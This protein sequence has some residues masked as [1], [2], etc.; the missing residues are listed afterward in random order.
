MH[1]K[2]FHSLLSVLLCTALVL[3]C[4][5]GCGLQKEASE[6]TET[7]TQAFSWQDQFDL[8][9]RYLSEDNY[10]AAI[11]A[12]T[13]A[14]EID[15]KNVDAYI[16][17]APA[18]VKAAEAIAKKG[19]ERKGE[20][21]EYLDNATKDYH[22][23]IELDPRWE[24]TYLPEIKHVLTIVDYINNT[25]DI[26]IVDFDHL[27]EIN[28]GNLTYDELLDMIYS[29]VLANWENLDDEGWDNPNDPDSVSYLL[30]RISPD[31]GLDEVGYMLLDLD[32][33]GQD[34]LLI[35]DV[36]LAWE[37]MFHDLY[38]IHDG[39]LVHL[40]SSGERDRHYLA[41]DKSINNIGSSGAASS[42]NANY[43][44]NGTTGSLQVTNA[45]I[46]EGYEN[47]SNP[48]FLAQEDS[49]DHSTYEYRYDIMEN[50]SQETAHE[51]IAG[52]PENMPITLTLFSTYHPASETL[53]PPQSTELL[54]EDQAYA[55]ACDFLGYTEGDVDNQ[56]QQLFVSSWGLTDFGDGSDPYYTFR[57]AAVVGS[58]DSSVTNTLLTVDVNAVTGVCTLS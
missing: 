23:I 55:I 56:G 29:S 31:Q 21:L 38:T 10:E 58:G 5:T 28:P 40:A 26:T 19:S 52:M 48:W 9:V 1:C 47:P 6:T 16:Q 22:R 24:E 51:I 32:G 12:F 7:E 45:V 17:R 25:D 39:V 46:Y 54:T 27:P 11:L 44:V 2:Y 36:Y 3:A 41:V 4:L 42:I 53:N 8:G 33:N 57:L 14:I 43:R 50:I 15:P 34:E 18:Y 35:S 49:I 13:S 37:G 20:V 30:S